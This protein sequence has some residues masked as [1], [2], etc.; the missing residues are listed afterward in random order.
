MKSFDHSLCQRLYVTRPVEVPT[1]LN[2]VFRPLSS[3]EEHIEYINVLREIAEVPCKK[4]AVEAVDQT[5]GNFVFLCLRKLLLK[6]FDNCKVGS[7]KYMFE[8]VST[9]FDTISVMLK[10]F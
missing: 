9:P 1:I 3:S 6:F 7:L 8:K 5:P 4:F 10:F 2:E